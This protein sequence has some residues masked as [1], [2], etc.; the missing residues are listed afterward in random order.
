MFEKLDKDVQLVIIDSTCTQYH[1]W[2][3]NKEPEWLLVILKTESAMNFPEC[4]LLVK[5]LV[6]SLLKFFFCD[7]D[8]F[9]KPTGLLKRNKTCDFWPEW[10][11]ANVTNV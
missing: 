2:E 1:S 6:V 11:N 10:I 3:H 5:P 4:T 8:S 9:R 7:D